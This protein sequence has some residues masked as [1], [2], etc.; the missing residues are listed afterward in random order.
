MPGCSPR[1]SGIRRP[2]DRFSGRIRFS[3]NFQPSL[4]VSLD[5]GIISRNGRQVKQIVNGQSRCR[6]AGTRT[7]NPAKEGSGWP[8]TLSFAGCRG[9]GQQW[10]S[11]VGSPAQVS[12]C[13][14]LSHPLDGVGPP[15][16]GQL[17]HESDIIRRPLSHYW[18]EES[19]KEMSPIMQST[20]KPLFLLAI[21]ALAPAFKAA[22]DQEQVPRIDGRLC[23]GAVPEPDLRGQLRSGT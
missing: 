19:A 10:F 11:G 23:S 22:P 16:G 7:H 18:I 9:T 3:F 21:F 14:S 2:V 6:R 4:T 1:A 13:Y 15:A 5:G 8:M 20:H 17:P 12:K